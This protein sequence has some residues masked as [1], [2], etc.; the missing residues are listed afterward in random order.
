[1]ID[2]AS[3]KYKKEGWEPPILMAEAASNKGIVELLNEI[4]RHGKS[5]KAL[6]RESM[7]RHKEADARSELIDMI[8]SRLLQEA[9]NHITNSPEFKKCLDCIVDGAKDPYSAC[10][11]LLSAKLKFLEDQA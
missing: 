1:M 10:D 2:I 6:P 3:K 7:I 5:K 4:E 8:K 11:E 9:L